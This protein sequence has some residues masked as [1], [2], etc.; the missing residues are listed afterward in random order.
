MELSTWK[1]VLLKWVRDCELIE[2]TPV[3]L[4][5]LEPEIFFSAYADRVKYLSSFNPESASSPLLYFLEENFPNFEPQLKQNGSIAASDYAYVYSLLWRYASDNG[6]IDYIPDGVFQDNYIENC[7]EL[8]TRYIPDMSNLSRVLLHECITRMPSGFQEDSPEHNGDSDSSG[9]GCGEYVMGEEC[10]S[11]AADEN[12]L[13][14]IEDEAIEEGDS[15]GAGEA[16]EYIGGEAVEENVPYFIGDEANE[17]RNSDEPRAVSEYIVKEADAENENQA[18]YTEKESGGELDSDEA[19]EKSEYFEE[20]VEENENGQDYVQEYNSDSEASEQAE[21]LN[22]PDYILNKTVEEYYSEGAEEDSDSIEEDAEAYENEPNILD[23]TPEPQKSQT[24]EENFENEPDHIEN[25]ATE[26]HSPD[27]EASGEA[28]YVLDE[29]AGGREPD[30]KDNKAVEESIHECNLPENS[31]LTPTR[32]LRKHSRSWRTFANQADVPP[33]PTSSSSGVD[34]EEKYCLMDK[35]PYENAPPG[36]DLLGSNNS[37]RT[38]RDVLIDNQPNEKMPTKTYSKSRVALFREKGSSQSE[39]SILYNIYTLATIDTDSLRSSEEE[40]E[41]EKCV[42]DNN[43]NEQLEAKASNTL[44][45]SNKKELGNSSSSKYRS[46]DENAEGFIENEILQL[47]MMNR[48]VDKDTLIELLKDHIRALQTSNDELTKKMQVSDSNAQ[49][50]LERIHELQDL[51][52]SADGIVMDR[53]RTLEGLRSDCEALKMRLRRGS[54][55]LNDTTDD[56]GVSTEEKSQSAKR[57]DL[58]EALASAE[59]ERMRF[60]QNVLGLIRTHNVEMPELPLNDDSIPTLFGLIEYT[61][62]QMAAKYESHNQTLPANETLNVEQAACLTA[63]HNQRDEQPAFVGRSVQLD[64]DPMALYQQQIQAQNAFAAEMLQILADYNNLAVEPD[65]EPGDVFH[66][67]R[68]QLVHFVANYRCLDTLNTQL[69]STMPATMD[70]LS[71]Y[72]TNIRKML[73]EVENICNV[74]SM[75]QETG[76]NALEQLRLQIEQFMSDFKGLEATSV[77]LTSEYRSCLMQYSDQQQNRLRLEHYIKYLEEQLDYKTSECNWFG[78]ELTHQIAYINKLESEQD[79]SEISDEQELHKYHQKLGSVLG[80]LKA[81]MINYVCGMVRLN[82]N[83]NMPLVIDN[84]MLVVHQRRL[85]LLLD[86]I[87]NNVM[88]HIAQ[89][90]RIVSDY[91]LPKYEMQLIDEENQKTLVDE[92]QQQ[93]SAAKDQNKQLEQELQSAIQQDKYSVLKQELRIARH[94]LNDMKNENLQLSHRLFVSRRGGES[95]GLEKQLET[96]KQYSSEL[97]SKL[98]DAFDLVNDR[99]R[100]LEHLA[101]MFTELKV[102]LT[103]MDQR[104]RQAC[105]VEG[106]SFVVVGQGR[107]FAELQQHVEYLEQELVISQELSTNKQSELQV[108]LLEQQKAAAIELDARDSANQQLSEKLEV[109]RVQVES[110]ECQLK[111]SQAPREHQWQS[112]LSVDQLGGSRG[113]LQQPSSVESGLSQ[114]LEGLQLQLKKREEQL[115][116]AQV[117]LQKEQ[118]ERQRLAENLTDYQ[119]LVE[120][121]QQPSNQDWQMECQLFEAHKEIEVQK[122]E[123]L[124]LARAVTQYQQKVEHL[125]RQ[126]ERAK[127]GKLASGLVDQLEMVMQ[128]LQDANYANMQLGREL[129]SYQEQ[130]ANLQEQLTMSQSHNCPSQQEKK[131]VEKL[132]IAREEVQKLKVVNHKLVKTARYYRDHAE[133]LQEQMG[134]MR[135]RETNA[136]QNEARLTAEHKDWLEKNLATYKKRVKNL[137]QQIKERAVQLKDAEQQAR[138]IEQ[139]QKQLIMT[140]QK[141]R[142]KP[143]TVTMD[144]SGLEDELNTA[145]HEIIGH[146]SHQKELA[147]QIVSYKVRIDHLEKQLKDARSSRATASGVED[148]DELVKQLEIAR[149]H[150]YDQDCAQLNMS[151]KLS[152]YKM[153]LESMQEQLEKAQVIKAKVQDE[154]NR[155]QEHIKAMQAQQLDLQVKLDSS[156]QETATAYGQLNDLQQLQLLTLEQLEDL[157]KQFDKVQQEL[158]H[159]Q[160]VQA[161]TVEKLDKAE[162]RLEKPLEQLAEAEQKLQRI[163]YV[164]QEYDALQQERTNLQ[165]HIKEEQEKYLALTEGQ[166][167]LMEEKRAEIERE[168]VKLQKKLELKDF[169]LKAQKAQISAFERRVEK[170]P[171]PI[172]STHDLAQ[173]RRALVK[174]KEHLAALRQEK[175]TLQK[176]VKAYKEQAKC[177][178][179]ELA[180]F[181][182][183]HARSMDEYTASVCD[184]RRLENSLH[185]AQFELHSLQAKLALTDNEIMRLTLQVGDLNEAIQLQKL[186]SAE[187]LQQLCEN[188]DS[189]AEFKKQMATES[190]V[191]NVA[192]K[193]LDS[194]LQELNTLRLRQNLVIGHLHGRLGK[195]QSEGRGIAQREY[196]TRRI[197][198]SL[199]VKLAKL[200]KDLSDMRFSNEGLVLERANYLHR[201]S[202]MHRKI[203]QDRDRMEHL[204]TKCEQLQEQCGQMKAKQQSTIGMTVLSIDPKKTGR[205]AE[206]FQRSLD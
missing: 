57:N 196:N 17:E 29:A 150:M 28:D 179:R 18:D 24:E 15:D 147:Q 177:A 76:M 64:Q 46:A 189:L 99:N 109:C 83:L 27:N 96:Y 157:K 6:G 116:A 180:T 117:D 201:I 94:E 170:S 188:E 91:K 4:D 129:L 9:C 93:L 106:T 95:K 14:Y 204:Q 85:T 37:I 60:K 110:L 63:S 200:R 193:K 134:E 61:M 203:E 35:D 81:K 22:S 45:Q 33:L 182:Q 171:E 78:Q 104:V 137:Q 172:S 167:K 2:P 25:E 16:S 7:I 56:I 115:Q 47:D 112:A 21:Y 58:V 79:M 30:Y 162:K 80:R 161:N 73:L 148:K 38:E 101:N 34:T 62:D 26:E 75:S 31:S 174:H 72:E 124:R 89:I 10:V 86:D 3:C 23:E 11:E 12:E 113:R 120:E 164:V 132:T 54:F 168:I 198:K 130:K 39:P 123:R 32:L 82:V 143:K 69:Q 140:Q 133:L 49:S 100:E 160:E 175:N 131:L 142:E 48:N 154:L 121:L 149:R 68:K 163:E 13:D 119:Q 126:L 40:D 176:E 153:R 184:I 166:T 138:T 108:Q 152:N 84:Q 191:Y 202:V 42:G 144:Q 87:K 185:L 50:Y 127:N 98:N 66:Q 44:V 128:E 156:K 105:P 190:K 41:D 8:F 165:E 20:A 183:Q 141:L 71:A 88:D 205:K 151:E 139:L 181:R 192:Q 125:Q 5:D 43:N 158:A 169:Q 55:E 186:H 195:L 19:D 122:R 1:K 90:A 114:Q 178:E 107:D 59:N 102:S 135:R 53:E 199:E 155:A 92:L 67:L 103:N 118:S 206:H 51:V 194:T 173:A 97:E 136:F 74:S 159:A 36:K 146:A 145:Y 197:V 52:D 111:Q 77:H 70:A 65:D 187:L